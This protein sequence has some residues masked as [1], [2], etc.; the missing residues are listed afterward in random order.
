M[1]K[2]LIISFAALLALTGPVVASSNVAEEIV[3]DSLEIVF[4]ETEKK[5]IREYFGHTDDGRKEK[6][7]EAGGGNKA[8]KGKKD[9]KGMPQGLAK[10][11]SLPPG[12]QRQLDEKGALPPGLQKK[13][14]PSDLQSRLPPAPKGYERVIVDANVL[15]VETATGIVRD[16]ITDVVREALN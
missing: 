16:V 1:N 10:R 4:T 5:L 6:T 3:R 12:L 15:L 8:K 13:A 2:L 9:K 14:L 11:E 7:A